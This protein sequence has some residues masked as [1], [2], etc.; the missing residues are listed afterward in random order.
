MTIDWRKYPVGGNFTLGSSDA[1]YEAALHLIS[2]GKASI[3]IKSPYPSVSGVGAH[4]RAVKLLIRA[5]LAEHD[6]TPRQTHGIRLTNV[7]K[8]VLAQ[9]SA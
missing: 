7:G 6:N 3:K 9:I 5:G 4:S 2:A 1:N 8:I